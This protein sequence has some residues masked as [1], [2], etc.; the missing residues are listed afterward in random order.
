MISI[1]IVDFPFLQH[2]NCRRA[3]LQ[4]SEFWADSRVAAR[5]IIPHN[6]CLICRRRDCR[7]DK[8][9]SSHFYPAADRAVVTRRFHSEPGCGCKGDMTSTRVEKSLTESLS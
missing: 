7:A 4:E 8:I 2:T 9:I 3:K 6:S 5:S 1:N